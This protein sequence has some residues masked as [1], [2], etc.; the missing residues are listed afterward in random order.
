MHLALQ[1]DFGAIS[2]INKDDIP[3]FQKAV[4]ESRKQ[5]Q[6]IRTSK[7][8]NPS[9]PSHFTRGAGALFWR[10][11]VLGFRGRLEEALRVGA[12]RFAMPR[13]RSRWFCRFSVLGDAFKRLVISSLGMTGSGSCQ[14]H[15]RFDGFLIFSSLT[16]VVCDAEKCFE[17]IASGSRQLDGFF[18]SDGQMYVLGYAAMPGVTQG[19]GIGRV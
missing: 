11:Q 7:T 17:S 18:P 8:T 19:T 5:I 1:P 3:N 15:V 16:E 12:L 13:A 6:K 14:L 4:F 2:R 10:A 9:G